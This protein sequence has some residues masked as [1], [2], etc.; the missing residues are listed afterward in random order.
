MQF[1]TSPSPFLKR[2]QKT[3]HILIILLATLLF[4]FIW[5]VSNT[6]HMFGI[7]HALHAVF[8]LA[9]GSV[10]AVS[11]HYIFYFFSDIKEKKQ[12][13]NIIQRF[14]SNSKKV[15]QGAP[16]ITSIIIVLCMP[17]ATPI[18]VVVLACVF[19]EFFAKLVFGGF[20]HNIF[21]P[22]AV[23]FVF[24]LLAFG[25]ML[26]VPSLPWADVISTA[27]PMA[28]F[29]NVYNFRL[30]STHI[31]YYFYYFGGMLHL[32]LGVTPGSI[33]ETSLIAI[34]ISMAVL[35]YTKVIDWVVPVFYLATIFFAAFFISSFYLDLGYSI[36]YGFL[37]VISGGA[38]F[39]AVFMSTDPV[40]NPINRQGRIIFAIAQGILTLIIRINS[41]N[42]EGVA[43]SLLIMNM[44]VPTIDSFTVNQTLNNFFKKWLSIM[45][46]FVAG[47]TVL[48]ILTIMGNPR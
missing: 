15:S 24:A 34:L 2:E 33:G 48:V 38:L 27:T 31:D 11:T 21:N 9:F 6:Y 47:V 39:C 10:S 37:H 4:V 40:T 14:T 5:G 12:F 36:Q 20:S 1:N 13:D 25:S 43:Y 42:I 29:N 30:E 22:A 26:N 46:V 44:F 35:T 18:F 19:A 8:M 7:N 16:L 32:S 41:S 23:G 17:A 28:Y 3:S 45:L